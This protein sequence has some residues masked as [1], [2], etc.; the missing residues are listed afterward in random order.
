[1]L[2]ISNTRELQRLADTA[3]ITASPLRATDPNVPA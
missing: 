3:A 2:E 1:M